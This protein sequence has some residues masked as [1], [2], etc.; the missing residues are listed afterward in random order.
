MI[1]L[2]HVVA[3]K[4]RVGPVRRVIPSHLKLAILTRGWAFVPADRMSYFLDVARREGATWPDH[5]SGPLT[6]IGSTFPVTV[7]LFFRQ[8]DS[9]TEAEIK[10]AVRRVSR[11]AQARATGPELLPTDIQCDISHRAQPIA[12]DVESR[13]WSIVPAR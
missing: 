13:Y 7:E 4:P 11:V 1:A 2:S 12:D 5:L 3:W 9:M 10:E 8:R 6:E